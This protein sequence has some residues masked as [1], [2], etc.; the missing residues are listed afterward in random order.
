MIGQKL[1]IFKKKKH[2]FGPVRIRLCMSLD[3]FKLCR[4]KPTFPLIE[5]HW[6]HTPDHP[7]FHK[8]LKQLGQI[9]PGELTRKKRKTSK[10]DFFEKVFHLLKHLQNQESNSNNG[11][12][13]DKLE[14]LINGGDNR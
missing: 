9:I 13:L 8:L 10:N 1:W 3:F 4:L 5:Q 12:E 14:S 7:Q 2:I 6:D 11:I